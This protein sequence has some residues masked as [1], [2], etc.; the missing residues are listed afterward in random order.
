MN[1]DE[2][3]KASQARCKKASETP[4]PCAEAGADAGE[5]NSG[6]EEGTEGSPPRVPSGVQAHRKE[7]REIRCPNGSPGVFETS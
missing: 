6:T 7:S 3:D 5:E 1:S 2:E 4:D